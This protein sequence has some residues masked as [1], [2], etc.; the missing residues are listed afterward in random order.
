LAELSIKKIR[1]LRFFADEMTQKELAEL[2][3]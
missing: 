2:V 1:G 3:G